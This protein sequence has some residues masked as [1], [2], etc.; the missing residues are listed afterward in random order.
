M[1][2]KFLL[3]LIPLIILGFNCKTNDEIYYY[4]NPGQGMYI[5]VL[6]SPENGST[7]SDNPP[8]LTWERARFVDYY[9]I[10]ISDN[11]AFNG[12]TYAEIRQNAGDTASYTLDSALGSGTYYW[13]VRSAGD[14]GG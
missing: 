13:K 11:D 9:Q 2:K 4:D 12:I 7:P 14:P 6:V 1:N 10:Q 3:L 5:P 8:T